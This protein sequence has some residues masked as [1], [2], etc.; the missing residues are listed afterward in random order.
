MEFGHRKGFISFLKM[1]HFIRDLRVGEGRIIGNVVTD[2]SSATFSH[3]RNA[4][5]ESK[6]VRPKRRLSAAARGIHT[7]GSLRGGLGHPSA[8]HIAITLY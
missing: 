8:R 5:A 1:S 3:D 2:S 6:E 4:Y 7:E